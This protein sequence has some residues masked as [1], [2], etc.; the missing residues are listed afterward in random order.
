M[1]TLLE[2]KQILKSYY[3]KYEFYINLVWKFILTL[4]TLNTIN[5]V[6]GSQ[7]ALTS[8]LI[9]LMCALL[10]A[11]LPKAFIVILSGLFVLAHL[12]ALSTET[13]IVAFAVFFVMYLLYYRFSPNDS[14]VLILTALCFYL[15]IPYVMP[16]AV[17]LFCSV[18]SVFS[19]IFG[20]VIYYYLNYISL[21]KSIFLSSS[22]DDEASSA[23]ISR[24]QSIVDGV[25]ASKAMICVIVVFA[26]TT[27][28]VYILRRLS[29]KHSWDVAI[30]TG[31]LTL[32][33]GILI[34][35][36]I[37]D[38][39]FLVVGVIVGSLLAGLIMKVLEFFAFNLD[40]KRIENVQ[41]EDDDY[42]YYVKAVP[43]VAVASPDRKVKQINRATTPH[44]KEKTQGITPEETNYHS[45]ATSST[46][47][48]KALNNQRGR[49]NA[50]NY[51]NEQ[52]VRNRAV[53]AAHSASTRQAQ[54]QAVSSTR[55]ARNNTVTSSQRS[56]RSE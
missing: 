11:I 33:I 2:L 27:V 22:A 6:I 18:N 8:P 42:Y 32:M 47:R 25:F 48:S 53:N 15:H 21:N 24:V 50:R 28:I 39:G 52:Q 30:V 16:L 44:T 43:K 26:I 56:N 55:R 34:A 13:A 14:I 49:Q 23:V 29:V 36:V 31:T 51:G 12:F 54:G 46:T 41:F 10:C 40:Y 17:G 3:V 5:S 7:E 45:Q 20:V 35:N 37:N 19:L 38:A 9:V 1:A 4:I